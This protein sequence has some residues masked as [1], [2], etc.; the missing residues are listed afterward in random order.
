MGVEVLNSSSDGYVTAYECS[1]GSSCELDPHSCLVTPE[2]TP[3]EQRQVVKQYFPQPPLCF[4]NY[5]AYLE[6]AEKLNA[7]NCTI[8]SWPD[9]ETLKLQCIEMKKLLVPC[10]KFLTAP[11][12]QQHVFYQKEIAEFEYN[13][14][15]GKKVAGSYVWVGDVLWIMC[16]R[17]K[18]GRSLE[19]M[20]SIARHDSHVICLASTIDAP[21]EKQ[22]EPY[23]GNVNG[24]LILKG[25]LLQ[26]GHAQELIRRRLEDANQ[27]EFTQLHVDYW[28][29]HGCAPDFD[30]L[31]AAFEELDKFRG[32]GP[33]HVHCA[34]GIN[35]S[36]TFIVLATVRR[37]LMKNPNAVINIPKMIFQM[38][39]QRQNICY[40]ALKWLQELIPKIAKK[41]E[42]ECQ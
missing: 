37:L 22:C 27:R 25:D 42:A 19:F 8:S 30:V 24:E 35:R 31:W 38:Q 41:I 9:Y 28:F 39:W 34:A 4:A 16:Q 26:M 29:D 1:L 40:G 20:E 7:Y 21:K 10:K 14:L 6:A 11:K 12:G 18:Q 3:M 2:P 13:K 36:G 32:P 23:W 17:P 33:L 15:P 5:T